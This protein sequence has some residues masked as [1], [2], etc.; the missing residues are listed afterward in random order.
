MSEYNELL[1]KLEQVISS[2]SCLN[3]N[4]QQGKGQT[5]SIFLITH[6]ITT[7]LSVDQIPVIQNI[8]QSLQENHAVNSRFYLAWL[9]YIAAVRNSDL[10]CL[11]ECFSCI[12]SDYPHFQLVHHA[13][14]QYLALYEDD[15]VSE[16]AMREI[17]ETAVR[18]C[19]ADIMTGTI[20][21]HTWC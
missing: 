20:I 5:P 10:K 1:S 19:G 12:C 14:D 8:L 2:S 9:K 15:K 16:E 21:P 13:V 3:E 6:F 17:F 7:S 18:T 11:Q 4:K